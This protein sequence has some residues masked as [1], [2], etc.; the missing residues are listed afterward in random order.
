MLNLLCV[1]ETFVDLQSKGYNI[2]FSY[3]MFN[4][5]KGPIRTQNNGETDKT[6]RRSD[7]TYLAARQLYGK[8]NTCF[9][10][11]SAPTVHHACFG[12]EQSEA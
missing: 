7:A 1:Y 3:R 2:I 10:A 12:C 5:L 8:R 9:D 4:R 11:L 6:R